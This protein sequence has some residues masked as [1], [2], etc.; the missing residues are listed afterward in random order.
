MKTLPLALLLPLAL[1]SAL[2]LGQAREGLLP[3]QVLVTVESKDAQKLTANDLIIEVNKSKE[4][5]TIL[6]QVGPSGVQIALLIDDGLRASVGRELST[7]RT[8]VANLPPGTEIFI[9]YMSNGR[10]QQESFFTTDHAGA[11]AKIRMPFGSAWHQRK[12]ILL[13]VGV[14]EALAD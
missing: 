1:S 10:I 3:T 9:G 6:A 11:A 12:P 5:P 14:C 7:L 2:A 4:P 13:P 8:F